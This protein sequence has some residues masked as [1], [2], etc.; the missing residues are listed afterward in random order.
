MSFASRNNKGS[1]FTYQAPE[2]VTPE[3][4]KLSEFPV[5][6]RF[7]IVAMYINSKGKYEDHPVFI[8]DQNI[9]LDIPAGNRK[10]VEKILESDEDIADI[11]EGKVGIVTESYKSPKY[12]DQIGFKYI[13]L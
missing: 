2:G 7:R 8:T 10:D 6:T 11:N 4:K 3:F 1:K 12:G 13:D 5:G 9:H